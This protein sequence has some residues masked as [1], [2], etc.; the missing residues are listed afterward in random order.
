L[1]DARPTFLVGAP[2]M[3]QALRTALEAT[4]DQPERAALDRALRRVRK[5]ETGGEPGPLTDDDGRVLARL[6]ARIGLERI[7]RALTGGAPCPLGVH[8]HYHALGVPF[9]EFYGMTEL[10]PCAMT[11]PGVVDLGTVGPI[12]PGNEV[13]LDTDGEVL[14]RTDSHARGYRNLPAETAATFT[15]DGLIHTGDIGVLDGQGRLRIVDRKKQLLIPD[16]GHN[17]APAPIEAELKNA[18]PLIG[19]AILIGDHRPFL[20]ALIVLEPPERAADPEALA[21]VAEAIERVNAASD[22][23]ERVEA[24]TIL[25]AAWTPGD[26]LTETLKPRRGRITDK[27]AAEIDAMYDQAASF[28]DPAPNP[29]TASRDAR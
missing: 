12:V 27:Y 8:E 29:F 28:T 7:N 6:R 4:L 13:V 2:R 17:T 1:L 20:A 21:A 16:H 14:V 22:P 11:R 10:P 18:C 23:R 5:L 24:H 19:Q 25:S 26:E 15:A 9:G 3:W